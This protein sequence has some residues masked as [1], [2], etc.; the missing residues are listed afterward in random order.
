MVSGRF[1][2]RLEPEL[3]DWLEQEAKNKDRSAGYVVTQAIR[4][5]KDASEA[6]DQII[7][8]ATAEADKGVFISEE[9]M[10]EW[11]LSLDAENELPEPEPDIFPNRN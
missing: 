6:R 1:S 3:K 7:R 2:F 9:K 10:T 11:F 5:L 4:R 8:D